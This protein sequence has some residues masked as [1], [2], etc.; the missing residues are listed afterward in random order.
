MSCLSDATLSELAA[1]QGWQVGEDTISV[2]RQ[3]ELIK[4]KKILAK[5]DME[6]KM[7]SCM[8]GGGGG[9]ER[10]GRGRVVSEA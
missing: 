8:G 4:P 10:E 9:E 6:S 1:E 7:M 2:R 5:I 3:V